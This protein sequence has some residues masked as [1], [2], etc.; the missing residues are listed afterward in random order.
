[1]A[2]ITCKMCGGRIEVEEGRSVAICEYCGNEQTLPTRR[3][4][5]IVNLYER[6]NMLRAKNNFDKAAEVYENI[7]SE[8][9]TDPEAHWGLVLCTYGIEYV[10][11]PSTN[12]IIPTCH[13]AQFEAVMANEE[14][15]AAIEY[16]DVMQ[17]GI[18][19]NEA[20]K[21]AEIQKNILAISEQEEPF[22]VFICYKETDDATGRRTTDSVDAEGIYHALTDRG[23]K[24]FYAA[25][26]LED[27]VGQAYEPYIFAALNSA[28]IMLVLGSKP[29]Y[30]EAPWVRNEWGRFLAIKKKD[31]TRK[32]YPCFKGMSAYDLPE[33]FKH[34]QA[35]DM[36]V[37]GA[38]ST[39]I[40][41]VERIIPKEK[42]MQASVERSTPFRNEPQFNMGGANTAPLLKRA[43][44]YISDGEWDNA[45]TYCEKVLDIDPE[46]AEAYIYKLMID[47]KVKSRANIGNANVYID[48]LG[49]YKKALRFGSEA[50]VNELKEYASSIKYRKATEE[51]KK[52]TEASLI[53]ASN[54]FAAL[55][56]YRDSAEK[57]QYCKRHISELAD[58][59]RYRLA[60]E[61]KKKDT[62][63]SLKEAIILF[64]KLM[65]YK[66]ATEQKRQCEERLIDLPYAIAVNMMNSPDNTSANYKAAAIRFD[67]LG[68]YKD[69]AD[70]A[71]I[72][73]R[74]AEAAALEEQYIKAKANG[75]SQALEKVALAINQFDKIIDYKDSAKLRQ[76][77][78]EHKET[79]EAYIEA[80]RRM[81]EEE[82]LSKERER[83][84]KK[85]KI[86]KTIVIAVLIYILVTIIIPL[87]FGWM[88]IKEDI[89]QDESQQVGEIS[90]A[91]GNPGGEEPTEAEA[92][93]KAI[94]I[95]SAADLEKL[96]GSAE[97]FKLTADID[98]RG[99]DFTPIDGFKGTLYGEGHS[100]KNLKITVDSDNVGMFSALEGTV[101]N[102]S[103]ENAEISVA[104]RRNH[105]G[106]LAGQ[107]TGI[108]N[109]IKVSGVVNAENSSNVGGIIGAA[110][111]RG[112]YTYENLESSALVRGDSVVGGIIGTVNY[113]DK[114]TFNKLTN[115]GAVTAKGI[116]AGGIYGWSYI[117]YMSLNELKNTGSVKGLTHVGG[118]FGM[119]DT[120]SQESTLTNSTVQCAVE[121][122]AY[123]GGIAGQMYD[124]TIVDCKTLGSTVNATKYV[125]DGSNKYAYVGGVVGCGDCV[126]IS[127]FTNEININYTSDGAY[128]GGIMGYLVLGRSEAVFENL[129][130]KADISG[131]EYVG[132]IVGYIDCGYN[133]LKAF[134]KCSNS[135]KILAT[136]NHA[137]GFFGKL[138]N[139]TVNI[140][141]LR[142]TG[143]VSGKIWVG[144]IGG[145]M[146]CSS[147][148]TLTDSSNSSSI[149]GEAYVGS[150]AG[151]IDYVNVSYVT[152]SGSEVEATK[153]QLDGSDKYACLGGLFGYMGYGTNISHSSNDANIN[154]TGEGMC[155]GGIAGYA[156][157]AA[158]A[159][160]AATIE[161]IEFSYLENKGNIN[162]YSY[163]G[164]IFGNF[165]DSTYNK[166]SHG[167][168]LK[169][170]NN[171]GHITAVDK[172]VGGIAGHLYTENTYSAYDDRNETINASE[173]INTGNIKGSSW[174]GGLLGYASSD[175]PDSVLIDCSSSG[176]VTATNASTDKRGNIAG[177]IIGITVK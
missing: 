162:G 113:G 80:Q 90:D 2:T 8:D 43:E 151:W 82:E 157:I 89:P 102:L 133:N 23:Y 121:A 158:N 126:Y 21:I 15:K 150:I 33:E 92:V 142:N 161:K 16:A 52:E 165:R 149:T 19:E 3:E 28:K 17:R 54:M 163:V 20:K 169:S 86:V 27:K 79:L 94:A 11:D 13:R 95:A 57:S 152:N 100:I 109:G 26:T 146:H 35:F 65:F 97:E 116:Y 129:S 12:D 74:K 9:N 120:S 67:A 143:D 128:V 10:K 125:I 124:I 39:L 166:Y 37:M 88:L 40:R 53:A 58:E 96:R 51:M 156:D 106:I 85:K 176:T 118:L 56:S 144:G 87:I 46:N 160:F 175:S 103:L 77:C 38:E 49:N 148:S 177:E 98:M 104:G 168:V 42:P 99:I 132:G 63:Q 83:K 29:E 45:N 14:Y 61:M 127:N 6:A 44:M 134:K 4:E 174:V 64:D 75:A 141:E 117:S 131:A 76:Q 140:S 111:K 41:G 1:M 71:A 171:S 122:E 105:V 145:V 59:G 173:L 138:I 154:Y 164:G 107:S 60:C 30:F 78:I 62:E 50:V 112:D 139:G 47:I 31:N 108:V 73:R 36:G 81:R 123:V 18:Y 25:I 93:E 110:I 32:L 170:L 159:A 22:D 72:C 115:S 5:H 136:S 167:L 84:R 101:S 55:G 70:K 119:L 7:L 135:G 66:D 147:G 91:E 68:A 69:S 34:I 114:I 137:G 172:Y 48:E 130:N 24:V 155:V 153:Y